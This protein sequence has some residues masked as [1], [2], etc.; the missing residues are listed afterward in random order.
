MSVR[1]LR[2][3]VR[4]SHI[5]TLPSGD[6]LQ[7]RAFGLQVGYWPCLRGPFVALAVNRLR[8]EVWYGLPSYLSPSDMPNAKVPS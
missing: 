1:R 5:R 3:G 2:W 6:V 7:V 4:Q 8:Y